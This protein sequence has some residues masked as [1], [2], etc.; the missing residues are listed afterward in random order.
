[1]AE[2]D[3]VQNMISQLGQSQSER[4]P[5]ALRADFVGMDERTTDDL[6]RF[7]KDFAPLVNYYRDNITTPERDWTK[8][9]PYQNDPKTLASFRQGN[10]VSASPHLA[11]FLSFLE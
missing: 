9:F 3:I 4:M 8:F 6:L 10:D 7:A 2:K 5:Q 11:L 1:M